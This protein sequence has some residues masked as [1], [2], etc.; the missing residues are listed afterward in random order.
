MWLIQNS[1]IIQK[2]INTV[3]LYVHADHDKESI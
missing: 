2:L 1:K 3:A